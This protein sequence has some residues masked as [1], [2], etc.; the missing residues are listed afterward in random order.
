MNTVPI[1]REARQEL[2]YAT[3]D[4]HIMVARRT[5]SESDTFRPD[6]PSLWSDTGFSTGQYRR[7]T[8]DPEERPL[9][10][11]QAPRRRAHRCVALFESRNDQTDAHP[12]ILLRA[13]F[14]RASPDGA[15]HPPLFVIHESAQDDATAGNR[16]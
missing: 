8:L 7:Y 5:A 12:L 10:R 14:Q 3:L 11:R 13:P 15:Q 4:G 16:E 1:R 9:C 2:F 6:K